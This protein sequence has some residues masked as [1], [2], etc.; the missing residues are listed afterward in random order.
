[1]SKYLY[2]KIDPH[3]QGWLALDEPHKMYWE[4]SGKPDGQPV[5]FLVG[6]SKAEDH[7]PRSHGKHKAPRHAHMLKSLLR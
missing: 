3:E 2:P 5:L 4:V 7:I 1:M 6:D